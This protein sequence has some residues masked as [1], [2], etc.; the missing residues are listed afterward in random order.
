MFGSMLMSA[1]NI[2]D[3][4]SLIA[5][6]YSEQAGNTVNHSLTMPTNV[7]GD[8]LIATAWMSG[9]ITGGSMSGWT[10]F[11]TSGVS[12]VLGFWKIS[13][14]AEGSTVTLSHGTGRA[15]LQA[16][17]SSIRGGSA[18]A[19]VDASGWTT[20][21]SGATLA[22]SNLSS[23]VSNGFQFI[24]NMTLQSTYSAASV[25]NGAAIDANHSFS[26]IQASNSLAIHKAL[27]ATGSTGVTTT[28]Y[29][30]TTAINHVL[31]VL[32]KP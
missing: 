10:A 3:G 17:I 4:I 24:M 23:S 11:G 31:T 27:S 12:N 25:D 30:G 5:T 13:S 21:A 2:P 1:L 6:A 16:T 14:G 32:I 22:A 15:L 8:L 28:T 7:A 26:T 19:P 29:G 9:S 20:P 18:S